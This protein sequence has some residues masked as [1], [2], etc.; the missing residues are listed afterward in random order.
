[1]QFL[2]RVISPT[3]PVDPLEGVIKVLI[4]SQAITMSMTLG[5][6]LSSEAE[7][8]AMALPINMI[9]IAAALIGFTWGAINMCLQSDDEPQRAHQP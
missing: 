7:I 4:L 6:D 8:Q 2:Q 5:N 9:H 3:A 1:M